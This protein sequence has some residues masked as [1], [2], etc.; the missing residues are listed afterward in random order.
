MTRAGGDGVCPGG[1]P[2]A[3]RDRHAG[4]PPLAL[5]VAGFSRIRAAPVYVRYRRSCTSASRGSVQRRASRPLAS[6]PEFASPARPRPRACRGGRGATR[7]LTSSSQ[8]TPPFQRRARPSSPRAAPLEPR[9]RQHAPQTVHERAREAGSSTGPRSRL[10]HG[11]EKPAHP[12]AREAGSCS[13][14]R[15]RRRCGSMPA[16]DTSPRRS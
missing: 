5:C 12:R 11:P 9:T 16:V 15:P 3:R 4:P 1:P 2:A 7:R 10:M 8:S 13:S 14:V 6:L